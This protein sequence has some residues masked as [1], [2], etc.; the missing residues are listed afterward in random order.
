M[1]DLTAANVTITVNSKWRE[2]KK[3]YADVTI[4]FGDGALTYPAGGVPLP[5][6]VS[7]GLQRNLDDL[8]ISDPGSGDGKVYKFDRANQKIRIYVQ[9][10]DVG[11]AGSAT[12]DDFPLTAGEGVTAVSVS[13]TNTIGAG[14]HK[15]GALK[16]MGNTAVTASTLKGL[17]MGW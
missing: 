6:F 17:V 15:L 14:V 10:L 2:G 16:E 5:T 3:R 4:A 7:F 11:A 13:L 9:G 8:V 12:M 1:A